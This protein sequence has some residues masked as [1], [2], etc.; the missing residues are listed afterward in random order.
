MYMKKAKD[1]HE[2]KPKMYMKKKPKFTRKKAKI[3][4]LTK[5]YTCEILFSHVSFV[6]VNPPCFN[7]KEES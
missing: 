3:P 2:K 6:K 1:V 7:V 4:L 5:V